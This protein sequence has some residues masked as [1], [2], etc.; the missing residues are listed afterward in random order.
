MSSAHPHVFP[1]Y[2]SV[3]KVS[4]LDYRKSALKK[5]VKLIYMT[6]YTGDILPSLAPITIT[7]PAQAE[8]I[9]IPGMNAPGQQV[10]SGLQPLLSFLQTI[11]PYLYPSNVTTRTPELGYFIACLTTELA[12][13]LGQALLRADVFSNVFAQCE[14]STAS[15]QAHCASNTRDSLVMKGTMHAATARYLAGV[16]CTLS[17]EGLYAKS[18][19]MVQC[20]TFSLR[21]LCAIEPSLGDV[22]MPF[23]LASLHP[24]AVNQSHMAPASM[25]A[26]AYICKPL[27][28]PRPILLPYLDELLNLSLAGIDANDSK[29]TTTTLN[30][31]IYLFGWIPE[32]YIKFSEAPNTSIGGMGVELPGNDYLSIATGG[33]VGCG[34][35]VESYEHFRSTLNPIVEAWLPL[36]VDKLFSL[37][38]VKEKLKNSDGKTPPSPLGPYIGEAFDIVVSA[39]SHDLRLNV[40]KQILDFALDGS[41]AT[42]ASTASKEFAKMLESLT[43]YDDKQ[44]S[45]LQLL[46][47]R[48]VE[49]GCMDPVSTSSEKLV[50][51]LR[52]IG[53]CFRQAK[54]GNITSVAKSVY[55]CFSDAYKHHS[56]KDVRKAVA[57]LL[58]DIL[59][60]LTSFY[61]VPEADKGE[62]DSFAVTIGSPQY[63]TPNRLVSWHVPSNDSVATAAALLSEQVSATMQEVE[64]LLDDSVSV[65]TSDVALSVKQK[66]ERLLTLLDLLQRGLRGVGE[67]LGDEEYGVNDK[68]GILLSTGRDEVLAGISA[69]TST[70]LRN[71]RSSVVD[72]V[73]RLHS[74]L[75][76][77]SDG[78]TQNTGDSM[79]IDNVPSNASFA[80]VVSSTPKVRELI[81]KIF[82]IVV[83]Q[84]MGCMK[85]IVSIKKWHGMTRR[86]KKSALTQYMEKK[87]GRLYYD[88]SEG[89]VHAV[90]NASDVNLTSLEYWVGHDITMRSVSERSFIQH[91]IRQKE[92][93]FN[94]TYRSI[95]NSTSAGTSNSLLVALKNLAEMNGHEYDSIRSSAFSVFGSVSQ[96]FGQGLEAIISPL[97]ETICTPGVTF[98]SAS[99]AL[100]IFH[101]DLVMKRITGNFS[102]CLQFLGALR[103]FPTMVVA[104]DEAD[105]RERL[106]DKLSSVFNKYLAAWHHSPIPTNDPNKYAVV[107]LIES[108][109]S[110]FGVDANGCSD[111]PGSAESGGLR[112]ELYLASSVIHFIGHQDIQEV[113]PVAVWSWLVDALRTKTDT[114]MQ[115]LALA[116]L[117][118]L[119][120]VQRSS[121]QPPSQRVSNLLAETFAS[122]GEDMDK[123][124][125]GVQFLLGLSYGHGTSGGGG[126]QWSQGVDQMLRNGEYMRNTVPRQDS[127]SSDTGMFSKIFHISNASLLMNA[128]ELALGNNVSISLTDMVRSLIK[129]CALVPTTSDDELR[130]VNATKAEVFAGITRLLSSL[131]FK[132]NEVPRDVVSSSWVLI[133]EFLLDNISKVSLDYCNDWAEAIAFGFGE[134]P[135][136]VNGLQSGTRE[137]NVVCAA[138]L[139]L[140]TVTFADAS[141]EVVEVTSAVPESGGGSSGSSGFTRNTKHM[142]LL[143]SLMVADVGAVAGVS[144]ARYSVKTHT[145]TRTK[146]NS[147]ALMEIK[148]SFS[149]TSQVVT[150][151]MQMLQEL[152]K[153][154][155]L[156]FASPYLLLRQEM[157][158]VLNLFTVAELGVTPGLA[159]MCERVTS[160]CQNSCQGSQSTVF[161]TVSSTETTVTSEVSD[162]GDSTVTVASNTASIAVT[163]DTWK[164]ACDCSTLWLSGLTQNKQPWRYMEITVPLVKVALEGCAHADIT[165]SKQCHSACKVFAQ[166]V[167][168]GLRATDGSTSLDFL[169]RALEAFV[170]QS[171]HPSL[172]IRETVMICLTFLLVNNT[173]SLTTDE[174]K[175]CKDVFAK[176]MLDTKPEVQVL[177]RKGMTCYLNTKPI[178]DLVTLAASYIKNCDILAIRE[179]KKKKLQKQAATATS[180]TSTTTEKPDNVYMTTIAMSSCMIL[181]FPFDLPPYVP[182]LLAALVRH[183]SNP[184]MK[185]LITKTVQ[186]FKSTHQDRWDEFKNAFSREQLEDIQGAGAAH[187]FS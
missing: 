9:A 12:Q 187:Y 23:M 143:I 138:L 95:N 133:K 167:K 67:I 150:R 30:M 161:A 130:A 147:M 98:S 41:N 55:F 45:I 18:Q 151:V 60:G 162:G 106:S 160:E 84:R 156:L 119:S 144:L 168:V 112:H 82:Q 29:K 62:L 64:S 120:L 135:Q 58:K 63:A 6:L 178:G 48:L 159:A 153:Q 169:S 139:D 107:S 128:C 69:D 176:G 40:A 53:G 124:S 85:N 89:N 166:R 50:L 14:S 78:Q 90:M 81:M 56:D 134:Y 103:Q 179:K 24:D 123:S 54:G 42:V 49:E 113:F 59:K 39:I 126:A 71:L 36:F 186:D 116:A 52:L 5:V 111:S 43:G 47:S 92:L 51:H 33:D 11:R 7:P 105:K 26:V 122:G 86:V 46:L 154:G 13:H 184:N 121:D 21:S 16:L 172:H 37:L 75:K 61:P 93:S 22:V 158:K 65:P 183:V 25:N 164:N 83:V 32:A 31:Y 145:N 177:S 102:L 100:N 87:L 181:A 108:I 110:D 125:S 94:A 34:H 127:C 131:E 101:L 175:L 174:K 28:F 3:M 118:K 96:R 10:L 157:S 155:G 77:A 4:P 140:A 117:T 99:G 20:C 73:N 141:S 109:L 38:Q 185:D 44:G 27:L 142:L 170:S 132:P 173:A 80:L 72:F 97:I 15:I 68:E 104:I 165:F 136:A 91:I 171:D 8:G 137:G 180:T 182:A 1:T 76:N 66:E 88:L 70:Y 115:S 35:S 146:A 74:S 152:P 149:T 79:D 57:K 17:L 114:P 2:F 19:F 163:N 148:A 129:A